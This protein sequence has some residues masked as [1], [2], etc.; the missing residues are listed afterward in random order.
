MGQRR[1]LAVG[2]FAVIDVRPEALA[3]GPVPKIA[4][5]TMYGEMAQVLWASQRVVP[6][7]ALSAG[8]KFERETIQD[9]GV[10]R[11]S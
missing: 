9:P 8:F 5:R 11:P 7:A 6:E 10:W 1:K 2:R 3:I 4:L